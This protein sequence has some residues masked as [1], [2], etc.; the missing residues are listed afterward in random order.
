MA[1]VFISYAREDSDFVRKLVDSLQA[2]KR[3]VWVDFNDIPFGT[4]WWEEIVEAIEQSPVGIFVISKDSIDSQY[5][6]LEIAQLFQNQ[7]KIVPIV[8]RTP[9]ETSITN[10]PSIIRDLNWISFDGTDYASTFA[11]L[12]QTIDTD[13]SAQKNIPACLFALLTGRKA[14]IAKIFSHAGTNLRDFYPCSNRMI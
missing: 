9:E 11:N 1:D 2:D 6:S 3:D 5:C 14:D 8:A 7:K 4:D 12:I 10:L 13:I